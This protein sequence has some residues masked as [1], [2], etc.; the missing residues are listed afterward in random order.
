MTKQHP[1][2]LLAIL[3]AASSFATDPTFIL[4][5]ANER[6]P[7][8]SEG[9]IERLPDGQLLAV[10][11]EFTGGGED[12]AT[13]HIVGRSSSDEGKTWSNTFVVQSN[14]GKQ[15]V[16]SASLLRTSHAAN[17]EDLYLFFLVKNSNTDLTVWW[18]KYIPEKTDATDFE[19]RWSEALQIASD[20]GYH[21]MNN[22]RVIE[23]SKGR[24]LAPVAYTPDIGPGYDKQVVRV[25][26]SDDRSATWNRN[27]SDIVVKDAK[28]ELSPAMEPGVIELSDGRILMII[29][30][31]LGYIY[32]CHSTDGGETW[33]QPTANALVAPAA[34][35]SIA[36][37][38]TTKDLLLIWNNVPSGAAASWSQRNPLTCAI[39]RDEGMTWNHYRDL[40]TTHGDSFAYTS[41]FFAGETALLSYYVHHQSDGRIDQRL[42]RLPTS[43]FYDS[44]P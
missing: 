20:P 33:S 29:R 19:Q 31:K 8:H 16:M 24:I 14:F 21:V 34:P 25:F 22:D 30:T 18:R 11:T 43:W 28:G 5:E 2:T 37:I 39:S 7:R 36:R 35:A 6:H 12:H 26:Y 40:E 27:K 3:L 1:L 41:I 13:A 17:A 32:Q 4:G 10:W 44:A 38:P 15:N 9:D 23:T 42:R